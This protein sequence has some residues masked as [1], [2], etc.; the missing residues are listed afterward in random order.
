MRRIYVPIMYN[1]DHNPDIY[2]DDF[3]R[4]GVED[5]FL[6][7]CTSYVNATGERYERAINAVKTGIELYESRGFRCGVW[8]STLGYG[9]TV[10]TTAGKYDNFNDLRSITG[11]T[12][13][14]GGSV[15]ASDETMIA[16]VC[17]TVKDLAR[18]GAKMI[19]LDDDLCQSVRPGL[20]CTCE[21]HMSEFSKRIGRKVTLEE[22]PELVFTGKPSKY[23]SEWLKVQG[24][25]LR[26]LCRK[27]RE[28]LDEVNPEVRMGFCAGY[29]SYDVEGV[30]AIELTRILAG[31]TKP[32]LRFTSAPYW[33][34]LQR[35]GHT[36]LATFIEMARMQAAWTKNTDIEVFTECDTWPRDRYHTP[37]SH[38]LCF[39]AATMLTE[40][41]GVLRYLYS[42]RCKPETERGYADAYVASCD[43][44]SAL[45][46]AFY[47]KSEL[48]VRVYDRM[49]KIETA[50]LPDKF[51]MNTSEDWI[52]R[53][54]A[55]CEEQ[56]LLT[57]NAIPTVYEGDGVCGIVFGDNAAY[58][59]ESAFK[60]GLI[61]DMTAAEIL[62]K[63]GIDVGLR[64][65]KPIS[66]SPLED[67]G[68]A[69]PVSISW[70][71]SHCEIEIAD[72][73]KVLSR[74]VDCDFLKDERKSTPAAYLYENADG[75]RFLVYAFHAENQ[76][77]HSGMYMSYHRGRQIADAIE[78]LGGEALP[79]TCNG[80]PYGYVRCNRSGNALATA[81][82]NCTPDG[83]DKLEFK[84][85]AP[86]K[87]VK[88]IGGNGEQTSPTT[89]VVN[90]VRGFGYVGIECDFE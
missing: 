8:M 59:P 30:D 50:T 14:A 35:F 85:V 73:A 61:I 55:F 48:G 38:T 71:N 41:V 32:F 36:P 67:F 47:G 22:L 24:D 12:S 33:L 3:K 66:F 60:K 45:Q 83:I 7:E 5:I 84:F 79:V 87:N 63:K 75:M 1:P 31:N 70:V 21:Y 18:A 17:R 58:L 90:D 57:V 65:C 23:R 2:C 46:G 54:Y 34:H 78:W 88:I 6:C 81:Y 44:A 20:S 11:K 68:F 62:Q 52:M 25:T 49:R 77:V 9:A 74:F 64:S 19:M 28:A 51:D 10:S 26:N 82:F 69:T 40:G 86:V 42:Y 43:V 39:D 4:Q 89:V 29:T 27:A 80:H 56:M 13:S 15:C 72:N 76:L 16:R 37:A 53:K